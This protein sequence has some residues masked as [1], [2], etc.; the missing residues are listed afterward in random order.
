MDTCP[1]DVQLMHYE[2]QPP[3]TETQLD[4]EVVPD[5]SPEKLADAP[6]AEASSADHP[7][8]RHH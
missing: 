7:A 3:P 8:F 1:M 5:P 2:S 6:K 4:E